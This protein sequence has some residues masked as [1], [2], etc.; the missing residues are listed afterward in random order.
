MSTVTEAV[1]TGIRVAHVEAVT[2]AIAAM[3]GRLA[4]PHPLGALAGAA[5]FSPFHFHEV[6]RRITLL[7]PARFLA[8]LRLAEARRLLLHSTL[9][10]REVSGRVGYASPGAFSA[11][12]ARL[13]GTSPTGFRAQARALA[14]ARVA[15]TLWWAGTRRPSVAAP[16]LTLSRAPEPGSLVCTCLMPAGTLRAHPG[17][18]A[19]STG[20][21]RVPLTAPPAGG[22]YAAYCMVI[23]AGA[24]IT[25]ALVDE[26]PGS[27][28]I[29]SA[30]LSVTERA[31]AAVR[32][33]LRWPAP[34]DP[35][36][37]ALLPLAAPPG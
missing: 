14:D 13:T 23:P 26:T 27:L 4:H 30:E 20:S 5:T 9:P 34:T 22:A 8:V 37:A 6:F 25:D 11:R 17:R 35:P 36:I 3:R 1:S 21:P 33:G 12:F 10:V 29:G 2:R 28:R 18:W 24:R 19:P 7:T 32:M 15:G 31:P 16:M